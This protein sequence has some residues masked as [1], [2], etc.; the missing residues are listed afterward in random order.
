MVTSSFAAAETL[1]IVPTLSRAGQAVA[2]VFQVL[3]RVT[4]IEPNDSQGRSIENIRGDIELKDVT[5]AYP[6]RPDLLVLRKLTLTVHSG[7]SRALVGASGSGKSS[8]ISLI[9]RFYD[10]ISGEKQRIAIAR[11][12]L[13]DPAIFLLDEAT[14][15]LDAESEKIVQDALERL[16][17]GRT[18]VIVAHRLSTIQGAGSIAPSKV[19]VPTQVFL[20][21]MVDTHASLTFKIVCIPD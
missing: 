18:T 5:L 13:K 9:E 11:A 2:S 14:C 17:K 6:S 10:P 12:V 7:N 1:T 20:V 3:D 8:V 4:Q 19:Q 21:K 15:A 16:M